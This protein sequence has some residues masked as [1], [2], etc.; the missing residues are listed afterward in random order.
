MWKWMYL[1]P[2]IT[3]HNAWRMDMYLGPEE[4]RYKQFFAGIIWAT[5]IQNILES[6]NFLDERKRFM[7]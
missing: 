2:T 5:D 4:G 6:W 7:S 1:I 3:E